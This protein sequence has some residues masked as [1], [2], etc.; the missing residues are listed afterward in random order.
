[1][2]LYVNCFKL[3]L[4]QLMKSNLLSELLMILSPLL[5]FFQVIEVSKGL[6]AAT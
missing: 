4:I 5:G 1:M 3:L 6:H 2:F